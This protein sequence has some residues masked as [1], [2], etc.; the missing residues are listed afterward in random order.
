MAQE[1]Q[2]QSSLVDNLIPLETASHQ[3]GYFFEQATKAFLQL[4][5]LRQMC[6]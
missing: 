5:R 3:A 6:I 4:A 2:A 1:S